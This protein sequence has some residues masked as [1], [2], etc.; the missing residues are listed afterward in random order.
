MSL[1]AKQIQMLCFTDDIAMMAERAEDLYSMLNKINNTLKNEN[2]L[3]KNTGTDMYQAANKCQY[4]LKLYNI[5]EHSIIY[6]E[7]KIYSVGHV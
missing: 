6:L 4:S 2:K 5:G 3:M 7:S 1:G